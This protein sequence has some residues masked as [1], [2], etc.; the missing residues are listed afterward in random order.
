MIKKG[1]PIGCPFFVQFREAGFVFRVLS[2][3]LKIP[4]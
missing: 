2:F 3:G 4:G 1:H